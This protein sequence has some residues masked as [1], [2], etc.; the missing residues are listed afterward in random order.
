MAKLYRIENPNTLEYHQPDGITSHQSI[1][2]Q[3]FSRDIGYVANYS[4]KATQTF[5]RDAKVTDG[6]RLIIAD[7]PD[8]DIEKYRAQLHPIAGDMDIELDNYILPRDGSI[9][10]AEISIDETLGDL[11]G[12]LGRFDYLQEAKRRIADVAL[13]AAKRNNQEEQ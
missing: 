11:R 5:G 4:R 9:P 1:I 12:K 7:V 8:D 6:A 10:I 13:Q 3:W 2:G